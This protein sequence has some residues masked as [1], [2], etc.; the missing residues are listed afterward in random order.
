MK[1]LFVFFLF[2]CSLA[3]AQQNPTTGD[4]DS[5]SVFKYIEVM[6]EFPGGLE[7]MMKFLQENLKYPP[8]AREN[9]IQGRVVTQFVVD[10]EG[11]ISDVQ[12]LKGIGGGCD[13]EVVRI[14]KTMPKWNPGKQN[15]T[16]VKVYYKM[17]VTFALGSD[18]GKSHGVQF[19]GY[20]KQYQ[21]FL[22]KNLEYPKDARKNKVEGVVI[23]SFHVDKYGK[24]T[25]VKILKSLSASCDAEALRLFNLISAWIPAQKNGV[26]VESDANM[27]I[28]YK[29]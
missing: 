15:G 19:V 18:D 20:E 17:P 12:I 7:K 21:K 29:L 11:N 8:D 22:R 9:G 3:F 10:E 6:P 5:P 2:F 4:K 27:V 14:V 13:E 1:Y 26:N 25:D 24:A 23:L 28:E 16:P